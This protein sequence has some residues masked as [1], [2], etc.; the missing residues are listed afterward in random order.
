LVGRG[1]LGVGF[2]DS[3][4]APGVGQLRRD[5]ALR[6]GE[7]LIGAQSR[8]LHLEV[9]A[10]EDRPADPRLLPPHFPLAAPTSI[11]AEKTTRTG[12]R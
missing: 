4:L 6:V 7:V 11:G 8:Q 1:G 2:L 5:V 9:D 3:G 10:V 12:L